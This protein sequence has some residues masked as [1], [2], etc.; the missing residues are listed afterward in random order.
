MRSWDLRSVIHANPSAAVSAHKTTATVQPSAEW[1]R[2][3]DVRHAYGI[4]RS[5]LYE[6]IREGMVRS[7]CL[8]REGRR[9]GMRLVSAASLR[10]YIES[11]A[12]EGK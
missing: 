9:G 11:H 6:L 10:D 2:P 12:E 8:R 7:I 3:A 4:G 1:L 5:L